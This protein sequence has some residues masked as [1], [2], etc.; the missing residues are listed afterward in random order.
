MM[1]QFFDFTKLISELAYTLIVVILFL[2]VYFR[3]HEFF[4]LTKHKG[5]GYFRTAF[6][7]FGLAY[8]SRLFFYLLKLGF[9]FSDIHI[10]SRT[11]IPY[12]MLPLAF[13]STLA[14]LF[15]AYSSIWKSVSYK[16]F[17]SFS[18]VVAFIISAV[19]FI[20]PSLLALSLLQTPLILATIILSFQ[21]YSVKKKV[22]LQKNAKTNFNIR[23]V[24]VLISLFWIT[25]I[26][27]LELTRFVSFELKLSFQIVSLLVFGF[28]S[29]KVS[30]WV[31]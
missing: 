21:N 23:F 26:I 14:I 29:Y 30:K 20:S 19:S 2:F 27:F 31:K 15:L 3:T 4:S 12:M 24:Y 8:L 11:L 1:H 22:K 25:N 6:L 16:S 13:L 10:H 17:I 18:I 9:V 7:L 5:I 28:L